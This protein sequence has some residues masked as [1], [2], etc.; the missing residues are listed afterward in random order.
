MARGSNQIIT[1]AVYGV[2]AYAG[3]KIAVGGGFGTGIQQAALKFK[4]I[5]S[6]A[7]API[8]G[9]GT[10]PGGGGG[11]GGGGTTYSGPWGDAAVMQAANPNF[12]T[13]MHEWQAARKA[14]GENAYDW[15]AFRTHEMAIGAP[16]PGPYPPRE[17]MP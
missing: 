1:L 12:T 2:G 8:L 13:Q 16:D 17:F 10:P 3:Y 5:L 9:G 4:A 6:G 7:A 15:Q 11:G 14:R